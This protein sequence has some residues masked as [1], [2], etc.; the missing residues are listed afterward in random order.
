MAVEILPPC[1]AGLR[2][3]DLVR[4][5]WHTKA[6]AV[7]AALQ[8]RISLAASDSSTRS[9]SKLRRFAT[10]VLSERF[11]SKTV[12]APCRDISLDLAIPCLP[13]VLG[14]PGVERRKFLWRELLNLAFD[15]LNGGH[16]SRARQRPVFGRID[17]FI[18]PIDAFIDPIGIRV[19][20]TARRGA[21]SAQPVRSIDQTFE[22]K[23]RVQELPSG[24]PESGTATRGWR[25]RNGG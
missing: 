13:V 11:S 15:R 6:A 22:R 7:A 14:K 19:L 8:I 21:Q 1:G 25:R 20:V 4:A 10:L 24:K 5:L 2:L 3:I 9:D 23:G 16:D 18:G 12:Q 17:A